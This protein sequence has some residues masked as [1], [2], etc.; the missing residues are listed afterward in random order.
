MAGRNRGGWGEH[1]EIQE[2]RTTLT[3]P[4]LL[5]PPLEISQVLPTSARLNWFVTAFEDLASS[6]GYIVFACT[7]DDKDGVELLPAA[8][9]CSAPAE[10]L[11][12]CGQFPE[13]FAHTCINTQSSFVRQGL[14]KNPR[15]TL[16]LSVVNPGGA[17]PRGPQSS[18]FKTATSF[19]EKMPA[20]TGETISRFVTYDETL[21]PTH[22]TAYSLHPKP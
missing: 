8:R 10:Q 6:L 3:A 7:V 20:P 2:G 21:H 14:Q 1:G 5:Q 15:Y 19:P 16:S 9:P 22:P 11:T 12:Q 4:P 13:A 17:G 18:I